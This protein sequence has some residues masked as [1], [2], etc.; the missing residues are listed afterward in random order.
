MSEPS[1]WNPN[2]YKYVDF[3]MGFEWNWIYKFL[4]MLEDNALK[5][6]LEILLH[7]EIERNE[8]QNT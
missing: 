3:S 5:E 1:A 7:L 4:V 8:V 6:T 2:F